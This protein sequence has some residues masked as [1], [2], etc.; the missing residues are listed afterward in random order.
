MGHPQGE[1]E[2]VLGQSGLVLP[3]LQGDEVLPPVHKRKFH[4][5]GEAV[6]AH[7]I[8]LAAD[9]H[10]AVLQGTHN[11]EQDG[12]LTRPKG[13]VPLPDM[14]LSIAVSQGG[15]FSALGA[16]LR[17]QLPSFQVKCHAFAALSIKSLCVGANIIRPLSVLLVCW[18]GG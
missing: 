18:A 11:G 8:G 2:G 12:V 10:P 5:P 15:Q 14:L 9:I 4:S 13:R 1:G 3:Q 6:A 17:L 16:D 7:L